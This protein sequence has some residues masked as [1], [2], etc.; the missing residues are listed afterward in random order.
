VISPGLWAC[1]DLR[2]VSIV[3]GLKWPLLVFTAP[4][5]RTAAH[6]LVSILLKLERTTNVYQ[7]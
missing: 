4:C 1:G 2:N 6:T 7:R 5:F 3:G